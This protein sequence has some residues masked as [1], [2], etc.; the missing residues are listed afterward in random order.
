MQWKRARKRRDNAK[1]DKVF[2]NVV[3]DWRILEKIGAVK[4]PE[5]FYETGFLEEH[6]P[7]F[8]S[9]KYGRPIGYRY[10]TVWEVLNA[11]LNMSSMSRRPFNILYLMAVKQFKPRQLH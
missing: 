3:S 10:K 4:R 7:R 9:I 2:A 6:L 11:A 5:D 1:A 8:L